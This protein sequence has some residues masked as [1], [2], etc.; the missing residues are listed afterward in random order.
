M[1]SMVVSIINGEHYK[2]TLESCIQ[3]CQEFI[4]HL[5]K[6]PLNYLETLL[7]TAAEGDVINLTSKVIKSTVFYHIYVYVYFYVR[8]DE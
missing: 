1:I 2:I 6:V 7:R 5:E 3:V 8:M 4:T